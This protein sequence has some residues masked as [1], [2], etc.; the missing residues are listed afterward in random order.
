MQFTIDDQKVVAKKAQEVVLRAVAVLDKLADGNLI[1]LRTLSVMIG[2]DP[3]YLGQQWSR[4]GADEYRAQCAGGGRLI[5]LYGN[6]RTIAEYRKV[7]LH[8]SSKS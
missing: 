1:T 8:E 6:K 3:T 2:H 5:W 7:V 4:G